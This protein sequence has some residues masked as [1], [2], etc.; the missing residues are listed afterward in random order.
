MVNN[1]NPSFS[2]PV[3][4]T[5]LAL[6]EPQQRNAWLPRLWCLLQRAY[7]NVKGGLHYRDPDEL[8][9]TSHEWLLG[10][11]QDEVIAALVLEPKKGRKIVALAADCREE[12]RDTA[13]ITLGN[14]LRDQ[15]SSAWS[16]VSEK[17]EKFALRNGGADF[18][19]SNREAQ[20]LTG[21]PILD[22]NPD[23]YHYTRMILGHAKEK[24]M[25]GTPLC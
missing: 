6:I 15:W 2:F 8:L 10:V 1:M 18:R 9:A 20:A 11:C 25:L 17:A 22:L 3:A 13:I 16:E 23:G 12:Q 5:T 24:L 19:I 14:L 7:Q 21:K 4:V